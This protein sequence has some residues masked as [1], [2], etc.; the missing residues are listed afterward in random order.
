MGDDVAVAGHDGF[1]V[2]TKCHHAVGSELLA[3]VTRVIAEVAGSG[4]QDIVPMG[5]MG[6]EHCVE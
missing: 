4:N 3:F 1:W 2:N 6:L 5:E